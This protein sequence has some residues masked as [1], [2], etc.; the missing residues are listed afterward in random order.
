MATAKVKYPIWYDRSYL[1]PVGPYT[2][3][4]NGTVIYSG[5]A[6][7]TDTEVNIYLKSILMNYLTPQLTEGNN[8]DY[9]H[10]SSQTQVF[11]LWVGDETEAR[12]EM[13]VWYD[14]SYSYPVMNNLSAN[15][16]IISQPINFHWSINQ[17]IPV[18][19]FESTDNN[20]WVYVYEDSEG[21]W[22][23][24]L[25]VYKENDFTSTLT[26]IPTSDISSF[27]ITNGGETVMEWDKSGERCAYGAL[28]YVNSLGGWDSFLLEYYISEK[29]DIDR[30][31]YSTGSDYFSVD[32]DETYIIKDIQTTYSTNTGWLS[33][34][35]SKLLFDN[36]FASPVIYF[37]NFNAESDGLVPVYLTK[38]SWTKK[39]W[40]NG[41]HLISYDIDFKTSHKKL[42]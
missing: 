22:T 28:Y 12:Y 24:E 2:I 37:Q 17:V 21:E 31:N 14:W 11:Q 1:I 20:D 19:F 3:K 27:K 36:L 10:N 13:T 33:D 18:S 41:K 35:Q 16:G 23:T 30:Q 4:H 7:G 15:G 38:T 25:E 9:E 29:Q 26:I 42:R 32:F 34:K 40:Q 8:T 6:K 5:Y 39:E